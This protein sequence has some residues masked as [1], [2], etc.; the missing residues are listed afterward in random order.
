MRKIYSTLFLAFITIAS[1][2]QTISIQGVL[3]DPNG[4]S[5]DDGFHNITFAIYNV[6]EGGSP[7]WSENY[8]SLETVHGVFQANLGTNTP[9]GDLSFNETYYVGVTVDNYAEMSPR[10]MLSTYPY[11]MAIHGQENE[12]P[13]TG[14]VILNRDSIIV[15]QGALK[16]EG[17]D[18]CI[19][20]NDGTSLNTAEFGGPAGSVLNP[21][22][23]N[24]NADKDG[25][26]SGAINFQIAG[27]NKASIGNQGSF[28]INQIGGLEGG[29]IN[30][31]V[32]EG[33]T[34][35]W[36][37][38]GQDVFEDFYRF[39]SWKA[40]PFTFREIMRFNQW[41]Q[42]GIGYSNPSSRV[43]ISDFVG[44][45]LNGGGGLTIGDNGLG[46]MVF[47]DNDIQARY[48]SAVTGLYLNTFGGDVNVGVLDP[49]VAFLGIGAEDLYDRS[50]LDLRGAGSGNVFGGT[51]Q[52]FTAA[53]H[54]DVI[55]A[56]YALAIE[57]DFRIGG[58]GY[59]E[60][61][62]FTPQG[63]VGIGYLAP[64][65]RLHVSNFNEANLTSAGALTLGNDD[66]FNLVFDA[67]DIQARNNFGASSL[68]LNTY[69]GSVNIG[70]EETGNAVLN[71]GKED[72]NARGVLSLKGAGA[73][74]LDG[75]VV[76]F[77]TA[78]DYDDNVN[79]YYVSALED[80]L[81]MGSIGNL[82]V[83]DQL[84]LDGNGNVGI[85][86]NAPNNAKLVISG[87][88]ATPLIYYNYLSDP[89]SGA[90]ATGYVNTIQNNTFS[91]WA[92]GYVAAQEFNAFSD[93]RIKDIKG[94]SDSEIDLNTINSIEITDYQF[95]D[96]VTNSAKTYKKVIAQQV[97]KV[98][99]Q[100]VSRSRDVIPSVYDR[101]TSIKYD[102]VTQELTIKTAKEHGFEVGDIVKVITSKETL[103][104]EVLQVK[105]S[106]SFV[107]S[108][109]K[110]EKQV[111]VY[112]KYVDDFRSVDYEA[113]SMLNVSATQELAKRTEDQEKRI[114]KLEK[115]N[116]KLKAQLEKV[117]M[118]EAKLDAFLKLQEN[119]TEA[120][121]LVG[122]Q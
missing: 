97:E 99:P 116:A 88:T 20:F 35:N 27:V 63:K 83:A 76:D 67:N 95:I 71:I 6:A 72:E 14:N 42:V 56:Y 28:Y 24:L 16:L 11:A 119:Q 18:G 79:Y 122:Q 59:G 112:G 40:D 51:A 117:D 70:A 92:T 34:D 121:T 12:F 38:Y 103:E 78:A 105:N 100:A 90:P 64:T 2:A 7:L 49:D 41:G 31:Q 15:K 5:V 94:V 81:R 4:R 77:L 111:F 89:T 96:K 74:S 26:G 80:D 109:T 3:R 91:L 69:G 120:S 66:S 36:D 82:G 10:I 25:V 46:N 87:G 113:I 9:F 47:D 106:K 21:S 50:I 65:S 30:L 93:Q 84:V 53:D 52:F 118:L 61:M 102:E 23:V 44:M 32:A 29:E 37:N 62:S 45:D 101:S 60:M 68:Y 98:F 108:S 58:A 48:D 43:Q 39:F 17:P 73:G 85:G 57:D 115:E 54:D 75:G 13:S 86:T 104:T 114:A 110:P 19:V 107:I 22:S 55:N 1:F 8:P 33:H